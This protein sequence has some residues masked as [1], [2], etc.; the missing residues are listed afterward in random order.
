VCRGRECNDGYV[1]GKTTP[2][3]GDLRVL[4]AV[5]DDPARGLYLLVPPVT[6]QAGFAVC[7]CVCVY[8]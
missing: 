6:L 2:T 3:F 5:P 1:G 4:H 8:C 7:P